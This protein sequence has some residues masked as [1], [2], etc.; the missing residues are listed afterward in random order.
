HARGD[1]AFLGAR[2]RPGP[3][4]SEQRGG[5][6]RAVEL[7]VG[8]QHREQQ[9]AVVGRQPQSF[10]QSGEG[11]FVHA[12]ITATEWGRC[13]GSRAGG[14]GAQCPANFSPASTAMGSRLFAGGSGQVA[15]AVNAQGGEYARLK[16]STTLPPAGGSA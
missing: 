5:L 13:K 7:E 4:V 8:A 15:C 10:G 9:R 6:G 2:E 1:R 12:G 14:P 3:A 11:R 16:S